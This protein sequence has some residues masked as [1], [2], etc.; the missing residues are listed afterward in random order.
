MVHEGLCATYGI[1]NLSQDWQGISTNQC[2]FRI[3]ISLRDKNPGRQ[4]PVELSL[5]FT[6]QNGENI[7]ISCLRDISEEVSAEAE[8]VKEREK[9]LKSE[10]SK[11]GFL[12]IMSH[13]IR[14]PLNGLTSAIELLEATD[15][16]TS[17]SK[18][19]N[20]LR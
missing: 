3:F 14:T 2:N 1:L 15:L 13:E 5:K 11:A 6:E 19:L 17:Q 18:Y 9:A 20:T 16:A 7:F 8:L 10:Q 4:L 12:P